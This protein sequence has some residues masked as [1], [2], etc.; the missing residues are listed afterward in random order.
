MQPTVGIDDTSF[1]LYFVD[2]VAP[3]AGRWCLYLLQKIIP[4]SY[5][6]YVI[7]FLGI[8][9]WNLSVSL[10][11]AIFRQ[12]TNR[13][14]SIWG[15][16]LFSC[17]MIS[18]PI[19]SEILVWYLHNGIFIGY[20]ITAL[21]VAS[22]LPTLTA[23]GRQRWIGVTL[24]S[25]LLTIALGFY[26]SFMI[27]FLMG[28]VMVFLLLQLVSGKRDGYRL[29]TLLGTLI[30]CGGFGLILRSLILQLIIRLFH[31]ENQIGILESR[32]IHEF[33]LWFSPE[34]GWRAFLIVMREFFVKYYIAAA[35]YLPITV[36]VLAIGILILIG[37][38]YS[39][40]LK[41]INILF[42]VFAVSLLPWTLPLMEGA[43]TPYR[44]SQYIPLLCAFTAF[45]LFREIQ[46]RPNQKILKIAGIVFS[47][48]ILYR[49]T[50]EMNKWF[51]LDA[52]KYEDARET[53]EAVSL[54]IAASCDPSKPVC[55]V[56]DYP[57]PQGLIQ[58]AYS[59]L[60]SKRTKIAQF[61]IIS[62]F[63]EDV[64]DEYVTPSGY[65]I[66]ETPFLSVIE[67]G[68]NAFKRLDK[69]LEEF[70]NMHGISFIADDNPEHYQL[71]GQIMSEAPSWPLEGSIS[72]Q[73][74][75]I[76]VKFGE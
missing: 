22:L 21:A 7:E 68:S 17:I 29:R 63:G 26:E 34:K 42:S 11:C 40:R 4:L 72:E 24:S 58:T 16:T 5:N 55:V 44:S 20:G 47:L 8:V 30:L 32:G 74:D 23:K 49:Q 18:S 1:S 54:K 38:I 3:A 61:C 75:H 28:A 46:C 25:L 37:L 57:I 71:A 50:Y 14:G 43:A 19:L 39:I 15:Y 52:L 53:M 59:P 62:F 36:T 56:G 31:L 2:G 67:W 51:H 6:P 64:W 33:M 48:F 9:I 35:V 10:W 41:S 76:I 12:I 27:V 66:A 13:T 65:A 45:L 60:W 73:K 69:E 70:C